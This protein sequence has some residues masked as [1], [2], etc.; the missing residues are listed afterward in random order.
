MMR[1]CFLAWGVLVLQFAAVVQAEDWMQEVQNRAL[2]TGHSEAVHWGP[3]ASKYSSWTNHSNRLIP[4][5]TFGTDGEG[6]GIDLESYTGRDSVYRDARRLAR[7]YHGNMD[8]SVSPDAEYLDQTNI[9][10]LQLAALEAGKKHI[11]LVVFDGMDWQTTQ[12]ASIAKLG[13]V[14]Y[15]EGRGV[16]MHFQDYDADGTSQYGWMVTS[17]QR[18][19]A[20]VDVNTQTVKPSGG[21]SG[22]YSPL[23]A[24]PY[25]WSVPTDLKYLIAESDGGLVRHAYTDSATS[26]TSMTCGV[27]SYN[28]AIGV[29]PTGEPRPSIA[30]RAQA[31]GYRVG[32]V[33]SVPISHATPAATYSTNVSRS[34]YQ[35]ITRDLLGVAS[36][37]RS[38]PLPGLDVLIGCGHGVEVDSDSGQGENFV[39]GNKYLTDKVLKQIDVKHGGKYLTSVRTSGTD[40][41]E[42]LAKA[43]Q[44]AARENH[45]LFGFYG[46]GGNQSNASGNLPFASADGNYD[47]AP[48]VGGDKIAYSEDDL[49]ENPTLAEMTSAAL[50]VLSADDKPFWLMVEAGDVDWANHSN[51]LDASAGAVQSGDAAVKVITAWVEK[52]SNWHE[53]VMIVTADHGHYMF[54][55]HPEL[56][57][58]PQD[59]S[60]KR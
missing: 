9:F 50:T 59:A 23:V 22:G 56:L 4:V 6:Q 36:I 2:K 7:L 42:Q 1:C 16:G 25:P 15:T 49:R 17:P 52:H 43:A 18:S 10:D 34:D 60:V 45:R 32:A 27:K 57:A 38:Q 12:A 13:R 21:L 58:P 14:A 3:D 8:D 40:G 46:I 55:E 37:S 54:I 30:H 48:H 29:G 35:D 33:T 5:Y 47:P 20:Q 39:P 44:Q 31:E 28:G 41:A 26:A 24:G 19:K 53:S 11:F 51:N